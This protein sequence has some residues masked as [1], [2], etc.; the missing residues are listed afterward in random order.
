MFVRVFEISLG[1][2]RGSRGREIGN[3]DKG[4]GGGGGRAGGGGAR[5][6]EI[7]PCYQ[8]S[9][10]FPA[11]KLTVLNLL[12]PFVHLY[13]AYATPAPPRSISGCGVIRYLNRSHKS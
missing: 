4:G 1:G 5:E 6:F 7:K 13:I 3:R 2:G 8:F 10:V 12:S 11:S 9:G